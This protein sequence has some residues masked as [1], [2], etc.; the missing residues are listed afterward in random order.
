MKKRSVAAVILLSI[1]TCGIYTLYWLCVTTDEIERELGSRSDGACRSG[2][3]AVLLSLLTCG[4]YE[5]YWYYKEAIRIETLFK[6]KGMRPA[7]ESW[8]YLVLCVFGLG[9]VSM[10]IMQDD[11]NRY[12]DA[13]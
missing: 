8:L 10:A 6:D 9:I 2:G 5:F 3:V 12:I 4:I 13:Q 11:L 7:N 1:V